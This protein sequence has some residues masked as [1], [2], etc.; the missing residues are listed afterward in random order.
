MHPIHQLLHPCAS[1]KTSHQERKDCS[2]AVQPRPNE[3]VRLYVLDDAGCTMQQQWGMSAICDCIF[4]LARA[5]SKEVFC[6]VELKGGH[7]DD[8]VDQ[9]VRTY[10]NI[11]QTV[12]T[13]VC[14]QV[15]WKVCIR[16]C[17]RSP[18]R[19]TV[20]SLHQLQKHFP[21]QDIKVER[22]HN[23]GPFLRQ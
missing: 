16:L 23:I 13:K 19:V 8:A 17:G 7:I 6:L 5:G 1:T 9:V 12:G 21:A 15:H 14:A 10:Q 22:D 11:Q 3:T 20:D 18:R 4:S 2:V